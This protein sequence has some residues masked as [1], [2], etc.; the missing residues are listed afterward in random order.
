MLSFAGGTN[1][2]C[3]NNRFNNSDS[4]CF[5]YTST[6]PSDNLV[7]NP[8]LSGSLSI[9]PDINT[10][11]KPGFDVAGYVDSICN[12]NTQSANNFPYASNKLSDILTANPEFSPL[13][14]ISPAINT[15][16]KPGFDVAGYVD[17]ICNGNAQGANNNFQYT[18]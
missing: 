16:I 12:D 3:V 10:I 1:S 8:E 7:A 4:N 5:P 15:V 6:H 11:I 14:S 2:F 17:S 18:A 9:S 13:S